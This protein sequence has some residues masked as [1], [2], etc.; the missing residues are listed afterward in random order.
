MGLASPGGV[1]AHQD[2]LIALANQIAGSGVPVWIHAF[3]DGR[4]MPPRSALDCMAHIQAGLKAGLPIRFATVTGRYYAMD[5][6]KRWERVALAYDAMVD[7]KGE[8]AKTPEEAIDKGYAAKLDDEFVLPTVIERLH[9]HEGRRR[10]PD[11]QLPLRPRPRDPDGAARSPVRRLQPRPR[12][13][14]RDG[15]R[16]G[17]LLGRPQSV[18]QDAVPARGHQDGPGRD[19]L[20]GRAQAAAHRRDREVR[21]RHVLLQ[22]RRGARVRR[23]GAHSRALAQGRRPTTSSPR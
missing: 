2:H 5:R 21:A 1:H 4:D 12:R 7:A 23:R 14:V 22:R 6:D 15:G 11:V 17:R 10:P 16:H 20:E 13:E 3:L 9:G 18:P 19:D 8:R